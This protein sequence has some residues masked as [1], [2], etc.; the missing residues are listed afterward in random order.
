MR[1]KEIERIGLT[2]EKGHIIWMIVLVFIQTDTD[3]HPF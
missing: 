2:F 1:E 3:F